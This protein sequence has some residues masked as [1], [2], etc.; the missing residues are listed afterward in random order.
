MLASSDQKPE[1][2]QLVRYMTSKA[3][4]EALSGSTA[5][6]YSV[7]SDVPANPALP[8]LASLGAPAVQLADLNGP[9]VI[10]MMQTAGLL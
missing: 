8:P 1:A 9:R 6:E 4:Q 5:L 7:A 10:E 2:Q 3:G